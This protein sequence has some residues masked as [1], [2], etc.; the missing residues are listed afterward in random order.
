[1]EVVCP[2]CQ[3]TVYFDEEAFEEEDDLVCPNCGKLVYEEEEDEYD[4]DENEE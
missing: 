1:V 2:H 4:Q 3:E